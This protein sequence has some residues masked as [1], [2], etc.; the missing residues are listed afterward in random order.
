MSAGKLT[1]LRSALQAEKSLIIRRLQEEIE[2]DN[3]IRK[4]FHV[5]KSIHPIP[6]IKLIALLS[7]V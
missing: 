5:L 1:F 6:N 3:E 2:R 7:C 4:V